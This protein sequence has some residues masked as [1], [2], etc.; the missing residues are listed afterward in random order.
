M[1]LEGEE[2]C[3][4]P[5]KFHCSKT[6]V[7]NNRSSTV[8]GSF[9]PYNL[10]QSW[11]RVPVVVR[12]QRSDWSTDHTDDSGRWS[13]HDPRPDAPTCF[14]PYQVESELIVRHPLHRT[15]VSAPGPLARD[16]PEGLQG[17]GTDGQ[18]IEGR[19]QK[20]SPRGCVSV[21]H[22]TRSGRLL[23]GVTV[24][25]LTFVAQTE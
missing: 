6:L 13:R 14:G 19:R 15:V 4:T 18:W 12:G 7:V 20:S 24:D 9:D 8:G 17:F 16:G 23:S 3:S 25:R 10:H 2:L 5:S 21:P 22:G 11:C 1:L